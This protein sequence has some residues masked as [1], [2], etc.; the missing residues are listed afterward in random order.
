MSVHEPPVRAAVVPAP[1]AAPPPGPPGPAGRHVVFVAWRDLASPDA[2]GSEILVDQLAAGISGRGDRA[3]LL[4]G[5]PTGERAYQV[6]RNGG[7]YSQFLRAPGA[8]RRQLRSGCDLVVE[9]CNGMPFLAPLW[10]R[11][12][13]VCLVN[14]VHADVWPLRFRPPVS[15]AGRFAESTVMPWAHRRSLFLTVSSSTADALTGIGVAPDRIRMI[16]NGVE[17]A[18]P[19]TARSP[20]PEFLALGR[21]VRSKRL[22]VLLR[23]WDQVRP[24][25][26]GRLIIAGDGP[27]RAR[28]EALAGPDVEFAGR[29]SEAEKHRLL[30]SAWLL[31]HPAM[32]EGWGI[33]VTEAAARG[34]PALGFRVPGLRDS[35]LDGQTGRLVGGE[36]EFAAAWAA[37]T[38]DHPAREALGR[39]A[40]RRARQLHWS[41]AVDGF[42]RVADE[43]I[44]RAGQPRAA[45]ARAAGGR[46]AGGRAAGGRAAG[47]PRAC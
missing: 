31:L 45:G 22:D 7:S 11:T 41:A 34:T 18:P 9:V 5:G 28:L 1:A 25:T 4:C 39:A 30:C 43:A 3:T 46:A 32:I 24:V 44:A 13:V 42:A 26:G 6:I 16:C 47:G 8:Y 35:V 21:L 2:G 27:E 40:R 12:P 29:V 10:T 15:L 20:R 38:V 23:L 19:L 17:P 33:V 14:H 36:I 37:L